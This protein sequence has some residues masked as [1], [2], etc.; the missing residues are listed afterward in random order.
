MQE[1]GYP[2]LY[3]YRRLV[4]A[5][6]FIDN[7]YA[8][9]IDL[10][11][12]AGE[13]SF[14]KFHFIRL[15]RTTYNCTPHQYLVQV[16]MENARRLLRKGESVQDVCYAVGFDSPGSFTNLFRRMQGHT[17]SAYQRHQLQLQKEIRLQPLKFIPG[18]FAENFGFV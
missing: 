16:R 9:N 15:F 10:D 7:H 3:L 1:P 14:S 17:P 18:C 4:Q 13:A 5:R 2:K 12:I 8:E 11:N 6:L